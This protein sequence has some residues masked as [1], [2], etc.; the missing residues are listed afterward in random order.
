MTGKRRI[1]LIRHG[2]PDIDWST[3]LSCSEFRRWT[4]S[5]DAA[6]LLSGS[7]PPVSTLDKLDANDVILV[8]ELRRSR[9][10]S[11]LL[12]PEQPAESMHV[13]FNE[14]RLVDPPLPWLE[15]TPFWWILIARVMRSAGYGHRRSEKG[16]ERVRASAA[17][18]L[19]CQYALPGKRAVL[20]GHGTINRMVGDELVRRG[21]H[22]DRRFR[23]WPYWGVEAY[24]Q[25][26]PD[27]DVSPRGA[28]GA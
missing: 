1:L 16:G 17:C 23:R 4:A 24:E 8:S 27:A 12:Y 10:S 25:D 3:R 28:F 15:L 2:E 21:W 9:E 14:L 18:T 7:T 20:V 19:L 11:A 6:P 5:Y 22:R 26:V 13:E